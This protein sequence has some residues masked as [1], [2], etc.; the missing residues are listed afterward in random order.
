MPNWKKKEIWAN[1]CSKSL[2][3]FWGNLLINVC[4]LSFNFFLAHV[5]SLSVRR[6][7]KMFSYMSLQKQLMYALLAW[8]SKSIISTASFTSAIASFRSSSMNNGVLVNTITL[9]STDILW[10][11]ASA[12]VFQFLI[13]LPMSAGQR[14]ASVEFL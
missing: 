10:K 6:K 2:L 3:D 7:Y 13:N 1:I 11:L 9:D 4:L 14:T 12:T 8:R 5:K